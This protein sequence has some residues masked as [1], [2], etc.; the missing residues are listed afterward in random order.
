MTGNRTPDA[1]L[2]GVHVAS[3]PSLLSR[4]TENIRLMFRGVEHSARYSIENSARYQSSKYTP[5]TP[6]PCRIFRML[7]RIIHYDE[8]QNNCECLDL[9]IGTLLNFGLL[10]NSPVLCDLYVHQCGRFLATL[11]ISAGGRSVK[12]RTRLL[13]LTVKLPSSDSIVWDHF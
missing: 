11:V 8:C 2:E 6:R 13:W 10:A 9:T 1:R 12:V 4:K 5:K 3:T 7:R